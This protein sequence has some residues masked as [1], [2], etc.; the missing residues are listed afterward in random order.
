MIPY[1]SAFFNYFVPIRGINIVMIWIILTITTISIVIN[2][3][4]INILQIYIQIYAKMK[5]SYG[6][7]V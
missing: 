6:K 7:S 5:L 4:N 2:L 3:L 1:V